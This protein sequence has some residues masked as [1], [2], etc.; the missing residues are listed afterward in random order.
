MNP[1]ALDAARRLAAAEPCPHPEARA[2][3]V[4]VI[5]KFR[6]EM[7]LCLPCKAGFEALVAGWR[8]REL[9][10]AQ[11]VARVR[12]MGYSRRDAAWFLLDLLGERVRVRLGFARPA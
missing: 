11:V 4:I 7:A 12:E 9:G 1:A 6:G 2:R 10:P 8:S 3:A 5:P